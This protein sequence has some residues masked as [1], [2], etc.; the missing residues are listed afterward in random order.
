[1]ITDWMLDAKEAMAL[2]VHSVL[3][4]KVQGGAT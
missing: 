4:R 2:P 3:P 1:M